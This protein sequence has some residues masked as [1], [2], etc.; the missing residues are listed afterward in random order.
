MLLRSKSIKSH[1]IPVLIIAFWTAFY[2][3]NNYFWLKAS[4]PIPQSCS[5]YYQVNRWS[6]ILL[7]QKNIK[8]MILDFYCQGVSPLYSVLPAV[9]HYYFN[10]SYASVIMLNLFYFIMLL[11]GVYLLVSDFFFRKAGLYA[12]SLLSL[13]PG[14]YGLSRC[15]YHEFALMP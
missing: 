12:V 1:F 4:S 5:H 2:G 7:P 15:F 11:T 14:I 8:A 13:Y 6:T 9:L 3:I 10:K